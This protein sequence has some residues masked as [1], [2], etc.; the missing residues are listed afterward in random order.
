MWC[1]FDFGSHNNSG[2]HGACPMEMLH[3]IQLGMY[4]YTRA[5]FFAQTGKSSKLSKSINII[6]S[7]MGWLFQRQSDRAYPR[8]KFTK[9]LQKGTLMAH[10]MTGLMLVLLSV[11]RSTKG[12][13]LLL[14]ESYGDQVQFFPDEE[15]IGDW[16]MVVELQLLFEA[17]LKQKSMK[18]NTVMRLRGK[19]REL[20][21]FTKQVAKR[22]TG[23][24]FK[25]NN[26]HGTTHVPDDI[27]NF[28]PPHVVDTKSNEMGHKP[29]K[30][31]AHRT[32]KRPK[33]FDIQSAQQVDD[34]RVIQMGIEELAGRPR[35]D[36]FVAFKRFEQ[37]FSHRIMQ[38]RRR[39]K[40]KDEGTGGEE[41]VLTANMEPKLTGVSAH[42]AYVGEEYAMT[43]VNSAMKKKYK[44]KY[45]PA[46]TQVLEELAND[47]AAYADHLVVYSELDMTGGQ[48][49][50]ASPHFQGKPWYDWLLYRYPRVN[51]GFAERI[52]PVHVR[53]FVDLRFLPTQN[54]TKYSP[55]VYF[56]AETVKVNQDVE[57]LIRSDI[58]IPYIK[59]PGEFL[60]CKAE[61]LAASRIFG[62][63]CVIP[64]LGNP[65]P[66]AF[67]AVR[68]A[69]DWP[70]L[71]EHWI[72]EPFLVQTEKDQ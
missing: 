65:N 25:I 58:F 13:R 29:D 46:I 56:I 11:L 37:L 20:L 49:Y 28:G 8:T 42:F 6:A 26:F 21:L 69:S 39:K 34:R 7:Q 67:Q 66:R 63:A 47:V 64:D 22:E 1:E 43:T 44:Y 24:G 3:W 17:W 19:V 71:F 59:Q 68:T 31:S 32:Q 41:G 9:G 61:L 30:G 2:V 55:E 4:K 36:Y 52:L 62:P 35:W 10:E 38:F 57:E 51:E 5:N 54:A 14:D 50:R 72:N 40:T 45:P 48:K 70:E 16:I 60:A 33:T 12:R 23:M 18:V 27:L 53:C 15:A